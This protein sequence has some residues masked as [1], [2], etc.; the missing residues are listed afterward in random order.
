MLHSQIRQSMELHHWIQCQLDGLD[1]PNNTK[2]TLATSCFDVAI[3]HSNAITILVQSNLNGTS[4]TLWRLVFEAY[5][6]GVWLLDCAHESDISKYID[7]TLN[8]QFNQLL[9]AIEQNEAYQEKTLSDLKNKH[10]KTMCSYTH[11]GIQ[12]AGRQAIYS[13]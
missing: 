6:R 10:Y 8:I 4:F 2:T 11:C 12:Q 9:E 13:Q 3:E 7:D 1:I 5:V